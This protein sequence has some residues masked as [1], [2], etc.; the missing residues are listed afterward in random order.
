MN[1]RHLALCCQCG[2]VPEHLDEVGFSDDHQLV[3]HWWC[4]ACQRLVYTSKPLAECWRDCPNPASTLE[5]ALQK[6]EAAYAAEDASF[7]RQ[8][9]VKAS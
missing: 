3:I 2:T 6:L 9:G 7:L 8:M 5:A 4:T 1:Y